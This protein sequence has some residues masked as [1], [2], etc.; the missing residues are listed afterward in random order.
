MTR[1]LRRRTILVGDFVEAGK[2]RVAR[3]IDHLHHE[4]NRERKHF[5][6]SIPLPIQVSGDPPGAVSVLGVRIELEDQAFPRLISRI[7]SAMSPTSSSDA[8]P[9][10]WREKR[11]WALL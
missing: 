5:P 3:A 2:A 11:P 9:S 1:E 6:G 10:T 8:A 7:R 4:G